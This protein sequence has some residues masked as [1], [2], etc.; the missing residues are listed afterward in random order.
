MARVRLIQDIPEDEELRGFVRRI[1]QVEG[2]VPN[3]FK[4]E[5][6]FP[7][8]LKAMLRTTLVLWTEGE[9]PLPEVLYIGAA[10]S[11][12][13]KCEYCVGAWGTWLTRAANQ[14]EDKVVQL[15][16]DWRKAELAE[17]ERDIINF[18]LKVNSDW[19]N[20]T[21]KD[22]ERLRQHGIS[23]KGIVQIVHAVNN[24]AAYNKFNISLGISPYHYDYDQI[25]A[26]AFK[27]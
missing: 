16:R 19:L 22:V 11:K 15:I 25:W 14:P 21:D 13:N 24:F 17:R 7:Q 8:L 26:K 1:Q 4:A 18:A 12:A 10:V 23:D 20:V 3:H 5:F 6:N 27:V 9:L 2:L